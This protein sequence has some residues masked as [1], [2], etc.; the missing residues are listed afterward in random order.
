[1]YMYKARTFE[2]ICILAYVALK[3]FG[4]HE[5]VTKGNGKIC[6]TRGIYCNKIMVMSKMMRMYEIVR[7]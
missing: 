3:M 4:D 1:M 7:K 5:V 2:Y 6:N